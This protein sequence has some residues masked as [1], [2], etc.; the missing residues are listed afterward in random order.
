MTERGCAHQS[1]SYRVLRKG[2]WHT[3]NDV[4]ETLYEEGCH[5]EGD[6]L[7]ALSAHKPPTLYCYCSGRLCNG[8]STHYPYYYALLLSPVA[9]ILPHIF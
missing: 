8:A 5:L 1:L 4:N 7:E 6:Q 3:V 2:T 9:L